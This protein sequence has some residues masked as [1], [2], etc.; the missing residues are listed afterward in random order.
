MGIEDDPSRE[1]RHSDQEALDEMHR[2]FVRNRET[3][4]H[5]QVIEHDETPE[6][7]PKHPDQAPALPGR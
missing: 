6:L 4:R 1:T 3:A 2:L 5:G 7:R